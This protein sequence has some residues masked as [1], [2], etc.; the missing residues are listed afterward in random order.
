[1]HATEARARTTDDGQLRTINFALKV[2]AGEH[3]IYRW[4]VRCGTDCL[5][6]PR[7]EGVCN[8]CHN[9]IH[10]DARASLAGLRALTT[11]IA[12]QIIDGVPAFAQG[13]CPIC[14]ST[15]AVSL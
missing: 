11:P 3:E 15:L 2:F 5:A 13:N 1:M 12:D 9:E 14:S 10:T 6:K 8:D 7:T 4:C